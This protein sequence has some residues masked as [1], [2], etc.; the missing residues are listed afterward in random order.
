[1]NVEI[2]EGDIFYDSASPFEFFDI[3]NSSKQKT[4]KVFGTLVLPEVKKDSYPLVICMHGSMGWGISSQDHSINFL[5]NDFAIFK[6]HSFESRNVQTIYQDQMQ[7]TVAMS[8][9]DCYEALKLLSK[10]PKIEKNNI[11]IAGW[12][13]GGSTAVYAAWEPLAEK[14]AP[15]GERFKG[16]LAFYP[17]AYVWPEDMR[18]CKNP[19]LSLIG[20]DDDYTPS[21][22]IEN[23]S[24]AINESGGNSSVILYEDSHHSFDRVDPVKFLPDAIALSDIPSKIDKTGLLYYE[25]D[26]E[27][28]EMNTPEGRLKLIGSGAV[29]I[30]ASLG[31]NW[32][33]RKASF[34]DSINFL[35]E[36][37]S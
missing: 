8:L 12:S 11:F 15:N 28:Y 24:K 14:L 21:I 22:L 32:K 19:I 36:N 30:G 37:L 4:Q 7:V 23:L 27:R 6:V 35:K 2:D 26:N 9:T 10:H 17:G 16:H 25:I 20:K 29:P 33:A 34:K 13:F 31:R 5:E 1:M 18:W 3:L